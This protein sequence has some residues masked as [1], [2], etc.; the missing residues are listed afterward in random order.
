DDSGPGSLRQ[1]VLDSNK[2]GF[3]DTIT[4]QAGLN[5]TITLASD[6][7]LAG[8]V[9]IQGPGATLINITRNVG[10]HIFQ[11]DV[12]LM[13]SGLTLRHVDA[14]GAATVSGGAILSSGMLTIRDCVF[15]G[16]GSFNSGPAS[17]GGAIAHGGTL[18][19]ERTTFQGNF[20]YGIG[21]AVSVSG[22][23]TI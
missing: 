5:G 7:H 3:A 12:S 15:S 14:F 1:A 4:F 10:G 6:L 22:D 11:S 2:T 16:N 23:V 18:L 19:L 17:E 13:L 8:E 9:E 21:G 20:I